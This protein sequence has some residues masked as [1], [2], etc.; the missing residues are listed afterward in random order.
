[1]GAILNI[2]S[3]ASIY[4]KPNIVDISILVREIGQTSKEVTT[5]I[6]ENRQL[7]K[8][9]IL[10]KSSYKED[11]YHQTGFNIDKRNKRLIYYQNKSGHKISSEEYNKLST[12]DSYKYKQVVEDQFLYY[13]ASLHITLTLNFN[14][15][16][17]EDLVSIFNMCTEKDFI[18][19]YN[20]T[21]SNDL[22]SKSMQELYSKCINEGVANARS[23]VT[24]LD[25]T[26]STNIKLL[27]ISEHNMSTTRYSK[28]AMASMDMCCES[29]SYEPENIIMPELVE[30]LFNNNIE[31]TKS[32]DLQI[33]F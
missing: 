1:M 26:N 31:L 11:S 18:C 15:T 27:N 24:N 16:V 23:I 2:T 7:I 8:D 33:E 29:N 6:N 9:Y 25:F 5:K 12:S 19:R 3:N 17:V 21:I 14:D 13:E 20:H 22:Y 28:S 4:V 32:L 10:R 30:E